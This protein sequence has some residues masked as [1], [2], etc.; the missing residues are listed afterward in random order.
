LVDRYRREREKSAFEGCLFGGDLQFITSKDHSVVFDSEAYWPDG[1][2]RYSGRY[3]FTKHLTPD[4]IGAMNREEEDCAVTIDQSNKVKRWVRNLE[5]RPNSFRLATSSDWFY[6]DFLAELTD[7]RT[8]AVEYK[9]EGWQD[10]L[11]T[12][13]KELVGK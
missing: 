11:D 1:H 3:H 8:M 10:T 5:R 6:P 13:E 9:G 7:G 12:A 4:R 2:A